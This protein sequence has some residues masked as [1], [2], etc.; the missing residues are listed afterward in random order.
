MGNM[1][2]SIAI[3]GTLLT[4]I[5]LI[6]G[7]AV[8]TMVFAYWIDRDNT[9]RWWLIDD[10]D[11]EYASL[12]RDG[13]PPV[14]GWILLDLGTTNAMPN[15]QDFTVFAET[16]GN[17]TYDVSVCPGTDPE[18][19]HYVGSGWDTENLTFQTPS[20]GGPWRYIFLEGTSGLTAFAGGDY[21]YGPD[22]DAVGWDKP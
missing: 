20:S 11:G 2:K 17:E 9:T 10:L 5:I 19:T 3:L 21:A 8:A 12:G 6:S 4:V 22:I 7:S 14:L 1:K 13:P 15:S 18:D 16:S